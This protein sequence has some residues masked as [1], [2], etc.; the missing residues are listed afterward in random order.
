MLKIN[1]QKEIIV[2]IDSYSIMVKYIHNWKMENLLGIHKVE[3]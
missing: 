1:L 2:I 3:T